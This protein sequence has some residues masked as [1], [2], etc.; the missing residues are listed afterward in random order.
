MSAGRASLDLEVTRRCNLRCDYCFVGWSRGWTQQLPLAVAR[1]VITEGAGRFEL[2]HLTGGEPFAYTDLL[3]L[4]D[5]GIALGYPE[6]LIN[7]N[8]TL[9][10]AAWVAAL[11]ARRRHVHLTVSLDG[12]AA[13]HDRVRGI[14]SFAKAATALSELLDAGVRAAV[15]TVVT[16]GVLQVLSPFLASLRERFAGLSGV[17]LFPVG[18][19]LPGTQKPG[20]TLQALTPDQLKELAL[21]VVLADRA[22][23][24]V[25]VGAYPVINPLLRALGYPAARLYSCTAGRGRVCVH[26]DQR[27]SPC[28]PVKEPVYGTWR[29]GL[30]DRIAGVGAHRR[31][32]ER[33]F[34]GC[35]T[36]PHQEA[37]GHC[38]AFVVAN[39]RPLFGNDEVCHHVLDEVPPQ[40]GLRSAVVES[41]VPVAASAEG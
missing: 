32:A 13:L 25:G 7:T 6:V 11:R 40:R 39:G 30:F 4:I 10:D 5:L 9:L 35:R 20:A 8:A 29:S 38:R 19:G 18:V 2:L 16:P 26:A 28:H 17:T 36:C 21:K 41:A 27:V 23:V 24:P 12:P 37:C 1:E 15:M 3:E 14:G 22:G 34:D 31:L 33:D